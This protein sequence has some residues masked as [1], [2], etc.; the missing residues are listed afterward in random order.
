MMIE[1]GMKF[2]DVEHLSAFM[3]LRHHLTGK[4][5]LFALSVEMSGIHWSLSL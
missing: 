2:D 3:Y 5:E 1:R 4:L